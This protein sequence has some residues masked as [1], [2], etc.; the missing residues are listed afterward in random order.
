MAIK[1]LAIPDRLQQ[2]Q[3]EIFA[4]ESAP[5]SPLNAAT[6]FLACEEILIM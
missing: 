4:T 1:A 5:G 6:L 2:G 3:T